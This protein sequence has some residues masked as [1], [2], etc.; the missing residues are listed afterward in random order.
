MTKV[1]KIGVPVDYMAREKEMSEKGF[2]TIEELERFVERNEGL[3]VKV[4]FQ[5]KWTGFNQWVI[6]NIDFVLKELNETSYT[7]L[8]PK[9]VYLMR[10]SE[11]INTLCE[12]LLVDNKLPYTMTNN[13]IKERIKLLHDVLS[14]I[15]NH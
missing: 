14:K 12:M 10:L 4:I 2:Y 13:Q 15:Y 6:E 1:T 3:T 9:D 5:P 11:E 8:H 7:P